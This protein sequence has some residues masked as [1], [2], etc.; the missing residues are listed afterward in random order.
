MKINK[1]VV[2][3]AVVVAGVVGVAYV[4]NKCKKRKDKTVTKFDDLYDEDDDHFDNVE[5]TS[6]DEVE[7][8]VDIGATSEAMRDLCG[9]IGGLQ[10][11]TTNTKLISVIPEA[12]RKAITEDPEWFGCKSDLEIRDSYK[13]ILSDGYIDLTKDPRTAKLIA[14]WDAGLTETEEFTDEDIANICDVFYVDSVSV[15]VELAA[16]QLLKQ[17]ATSPQQKGNKNQG[18]KNQT[19]ETK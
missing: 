5:E 14:E 15:R 2:I 4:I 19:E 7:K 3:G 1:N 12:I 11:Q 8:P 16:S 18:N 6:V 13:K 9:S 17:K 10:N